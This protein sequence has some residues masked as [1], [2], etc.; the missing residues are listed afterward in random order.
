M[1]SACRIACA[2]LAFGFVCS[3]Q[4][5]LHELRAERDPGRRAEKALEY[6][7][8]SFDA[9]REFYDKGLVHKGDEQL[10]YMTAALK[11]CVDA[12]DQAHKARIYKKAELNVAMLQRRMN[13][14]LDDL[15]IQERGWAEYTSRKVDE[16]HDKILEGVMRK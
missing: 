13:G 15:S 7:D 1:I 16:M 14:L 4:S 8:E 10:D 12:L 2:M 6:A 3:G 5:F 11:E 9:A